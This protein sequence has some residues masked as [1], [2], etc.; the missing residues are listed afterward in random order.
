MSALGYIALLV[1]VILD[2]YGDYRFRKQIGEL[3]FRLE[4]LETVTGHILIDIDALDEELD[5]SDN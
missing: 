5:E 2:M 4:T 1:Y 3:E